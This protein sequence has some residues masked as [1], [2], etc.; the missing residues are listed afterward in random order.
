MSENPRGVWRK[1]K[2]QQRKTQINKGGIIYD[3]NI[4]AQTIFLYPELR[5]LTLVELVKREVLK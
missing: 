4:D 5:M 2:V 3:F 1:I